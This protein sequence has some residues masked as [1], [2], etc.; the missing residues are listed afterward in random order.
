MG[1]SGQMLFGGMLAGI[2]ALHAGSSVPTGVGQ[3][4][5]ILICILGSMT[6]SAFA[7]FLKAYFRI[8]EVV[9]TIMLN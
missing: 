8:H 1:V 2:V 4:L 7:G 6:F 3:I 5:I 9:S